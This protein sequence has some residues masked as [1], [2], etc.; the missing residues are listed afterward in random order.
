MKKIL[1][2][3]LL[4]PPA[5]AANSFDNF[6][7]VEQGG[8]GMSTP[9][10][11]LSCFHD[12]DNSVSLCVY[13]NDTSITGI[14]SPNKATDANA[15]NLT[16]HAENVK[17]NATAARTAGHL[18]LAGGLD[19][20]TVDFTPAGANPDTG[21]LCTG[22]DTVTVTVNSTAT[23]FT[24]TV[25]CA[26]GCTTR[27]AACAALSGAINTAAIGVTSTCGTIT[28]GVADAVL[29]SANQPAS[30]AITL[31]QNDATCTTISNGTDGC[32]QI[33]GVAFLKAP[34]SSVVFGS[35][36]GAQTLSVAGANAN[37]NG[38]ITAVNIIQNTLTSV[39]GTG[40]TYTLT[41]KG[42]KYLPT[43][44]VDATYAF[45]AG[46][47][48]TIEHA[49]V[50]K[51]ATSVQCTGYVTTAESGGGCTG[52][53][54]GN[55]V[56][57]ARADRYGTGLAITAGSRWS[58]ALGSPTAGSFDCYGGTDCGIILT[59]TGGGAACK[60]MVVRVTCSYTLLSADTG[61]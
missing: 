51:G 52:Y 8:S 54:A 14:S 29:I 9:S 58:P 12:T 19:S 35:T 17:A 4:S 10:A 7:I 37:F 59:S 50:P 43:F 25:Y 46:G 47:T 22:V 11:G 38:Y 15:G 55:T 32:L 34:S 42:A 48:A 36:C 40:G 21:G 33:G 26:G 31:S 5:Y 57:S 30:F 44:K 56:V 61:A 39:D 27:A 49:I 13:T 1:A 3:M 60:N 20:K 6:R 16:I 2:L 28:G 18:V 24:Y 23:V 53:T 45:A 41:P